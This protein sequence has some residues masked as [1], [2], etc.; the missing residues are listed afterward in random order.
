MIRVGG[1]YR[2]SLNGYI[3]SDYFL[4]EEFDGEFYFGRYG[5]FFGA[6][7]KFTE[8]GR[9]IGHNLS[10]HEQGE[11]PNWRLIIEDDDAKSR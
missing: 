10:P 11:V 1:K 6:L 4:I 8:D 5:Q 3:S 7:Y 9:Q 2:Y